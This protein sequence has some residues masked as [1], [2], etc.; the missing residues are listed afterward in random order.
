MSTEGNLTYYY[1]YEVFTIFLVP[2]DVWDLA[3]DDPELL[4]DIK[5]V[6]EAL[7]NQ[8]SEAIATATL[9]VVA[10]KGHIT[11]HVPHVKGTGSCNKK[12]S[13]AFKGPPV[14]K[15]SKGG[16]FE[17]DIDR[18]KAVLTLKTDGKV[19]FGPTTYH[20]AEKGI[21]GKWTGKWA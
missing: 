18:T 2:D 15:H 8:A 7:N 21:T 14:P 16:E 19:V 6:E 10:A 17:L 11:F 20:G 4:G 5:E 13:G 9:K 1:L 3:A 12:G